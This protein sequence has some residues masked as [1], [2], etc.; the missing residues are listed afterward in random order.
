[1]WADQVYT[2]KYSRGPTRV[3]KVVNVG[4]LLVLNVIQYTALHNAFEMTKV[5]FIPLT[6]DH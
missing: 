2:V 4:W 5:F 6:L 3:V 1:M